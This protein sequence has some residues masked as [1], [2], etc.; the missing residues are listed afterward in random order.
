M[1]KG[2]APSHYSVTS[3]P[4]N[5]FVLGDLVLDHAIFVRRKDTPFE[6]VGNEKV[7]E[8][9]TRITMAGGAANCARALAAVGKGH[10]FLWGITGRSPW[11]EFSDV[12]SRSHIYDCAV[13]S[14]RVSF[15]GYHDQS[16]PMNTITRLITVSEDKHEH[17]HEHRFDDV[18]QVHVTE[19]V[20]DTV[21]HELR[22]AH[23]K[24]ILHAVIINDLDMLTIEQE[25]V[26]AVSKFCL[27]S[28]IPLF[29]DPKRTISKYSNVSA[30][31]ILPNLN[32]WC[33]LVGQHN[34]DD[35]WRKKI[36]HREGLQELASFS[37]EKLPNFT[38]QII[39]CDRDGAVL[40]APSG[41]K[42]AHFE[43][44][45]V[46]PHPTRPR[47][48]PHQL[49][50]GDVITAVLA[51]QYCSKRDRDES[52]K[53]LRD[54]YLTANLVVASYRQNTW[55]RM[56]IRAEIENLHTRIPQIENSELV[57]VPR[58]Y[59]PKDKEIDLSKYE[60][61]IKN[62]VSI[63]EEYIR[64][65]N[66]LVS[67][68]QENWRAQTLFSAFLTARGG[69]GKTQVCKG[70]SSVVEDQRIGYLL[71]GPRTEVEVHTK[72]K[73]WNYVK[74]EKKA[75]G[76]EHL[77]VAVDEAFGTI[78]FLLR[79]KNGVMLLEDAA[80]SGVRFLF[81]DA[82]FKRL[83][84]NL[85]GS[86]FVSRI[87]MFRLPELGER[88]CDIPYIFAAG[89]EAAASEMSASKL[90]CDEEALLAVIEATL[91][92]PREHQSARDVFNW[93]KKAVIKPSKGKR[94][95]VQ[96]T[97]DKLPRS[98]NTKSRLAAKNQKWYSIKLKGTR[99]V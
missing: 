63:D 29:V 28:S 97:V 66:E 37:L 42:P 98:L 88:P 1:A 4:L 70:L 92:T 48:L 44:L 14:G 35:H 64:V 74:Q 80:T 3:I 33:A 45:H 43:V 54:A 82:D 24:D 30:T 18:G 57:T 41:D 59:L 16:I 89:C 6:A 78:P 62:L 22:Q 65:L 19:A 47:D 71:I 20:R 58:R 69:S 7:T 11:G 46:P 31:A 23:N 60:S 86:Q 91:T 10:T 85:S 50:T 90:L 36:G 93:G 8:V 77:L 56:P 68:F 12:L 51:L 40:I 73:F 95:K 75:L 83:G 99:D 76:V 17:E 67:F 84:S 39:T 26:E 9:R 21:I 79:R 27:E 53:K 15:R 2:S 52:M 96:I 49:G 32:E 55:H 94:T 25:L 61:P 72:T 13:I 87:Q 38:Y 81:I 34:R 5:I